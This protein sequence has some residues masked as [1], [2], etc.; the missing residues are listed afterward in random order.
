MTQENFPVFFW[1]GFLIFVLIGFVLSLRKC[2]VCG[3]RGHHEED[4]CSK[5]PQQVRQKFIDCPMCL[6]AGEQEKLRRADE[7][8]E[9]DLDRLAE[10]VAAKL[11][12]RQKSLEE[13]LK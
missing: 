3:K 12:K 11:A 5:H 4:H 6:V 9:R 1:C 7:K 2:K 10:K 13:N 8:H